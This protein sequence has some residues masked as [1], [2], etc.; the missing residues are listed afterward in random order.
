MVLDLEGFTKLINLGIGLVLPDC[1]LN[2]CKHLNMA[3][4]IFS[5]LQ[6]LKCLKIEEKIY[7]IPP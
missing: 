7:R 1:G 2:F 6:N 4:C 5:S 3:P